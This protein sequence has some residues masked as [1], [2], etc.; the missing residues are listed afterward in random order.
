MV[1]KD[2]EANVGPIIYASDLEVCTWFSLNSPF[3]NDNPQD[4]WIFMETGNNYILRGNMRVLKP[5]YYF[6]T[7]VKNFSLA[8]SQKSVVVC[9]LKNASECYYRYFPS[10][11]SQSASPGENI[12]VNVVASDDYDHETTAFLEI[13]VWLGL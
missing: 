7:I 11:C 12:I 8:E 6:Q 4:G 13:K 9:G 1:F 3:F 2:N 5:G 10:I